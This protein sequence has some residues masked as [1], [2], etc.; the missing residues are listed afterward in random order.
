MGSTTTTLVGHVLSH[1]SLSC[2]VTGM[3]ALALD[4]SLESA[5]ESSSALGGHA[6]GVLLWLGP[7][8]LQLHVAPGLRLLSVPTYTLR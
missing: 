1:K 6:P 3:S 8:K 7:S 5:A 4:T 2:L